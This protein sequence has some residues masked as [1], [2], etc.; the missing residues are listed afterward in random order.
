MRRYAN[1][2]DYEL[3]YLYRNGSEAALNVL[4]S[5]YYILVEKIV[6]EL[7]YCYNL[8]SK[9]QISDL[10]QEGIMVVYRCLN[11]F[12]ESSNV[13]F[14][15][16]ALVAI[17]RRIFNLIN[18][19]TYYYKYIK[20]DDTMISLLDSSISNAYNKKS[21]IYSGEKLFKSE[22]EI[23]IYEEC[24]LGDTKYSEFATYYKY[25][26]SLVIKIKNRLIKKLKYL[27]A[28]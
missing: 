11:T 15:N 13:A 23:L 12:K 7:Y 2:N 25:D 28:L 22:I 19:D 6:K 8:F 27:L 24:I 10:I 26:Y 4:I 14:Y 18:K 5:K 21:H 3:I 16:Y 9:E 1:Y 20:L 17:R